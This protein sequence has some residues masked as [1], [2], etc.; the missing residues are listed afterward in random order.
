MNKKY[1]PTTCEGK[2]LHV[3]E[4]C[5]EVQHAITKAM[6]FGLDK[7]HPRDVHLDNR[8]KILSELDDLES[9]I[10]KLRDAL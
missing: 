2:M 6:R 3:I 4:E 7:Y 1:L 5:S 8:N 10:S 9:A